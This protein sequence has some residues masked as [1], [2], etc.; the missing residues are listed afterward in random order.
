MKIK[1]WRDHRYNE[2]LFQISIPDME[3]DIL[4][5]AFIN[6]SAYE[7]SISDILILLAMAARLLEV[8]EEER[9]SEMIEVGI[10]ATNKNSELPSG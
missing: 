4:D 2:T 3:T 10:A 1:T 8:R 6:P 9:I 7:G 5:R